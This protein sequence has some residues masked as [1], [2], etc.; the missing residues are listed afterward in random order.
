MDSQLS[1]S[2]KKRRAKGIEQLVF[3]LAALPLGE[4]ASLPCEQ[5]IRDEISS[6]KNLKGGA[7][8]RQLKYATKLLRDM[9]IEDLYDF[10]SRKKGS[11][12]KEK[13]EFQ[14]LEN[15]RNLLLT[16]VVKLYEETMQSNGFLNESEPEE[17]LHDSETIQAI[18]L[19]IPD[20]DETQLK[21]T[22]IQFAKTRNRKFSRELFRIMKAATEKAQF[23]QKQDQNDGI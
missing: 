3:E 21:N 7:R 13:R 8:K 2:E 11:M 15:F 17:L 6:A 10:L 9:P 1:K 19:H 18:L 12:L 20:I 5:E 4:I 23:S 22:A 14:E 16:E